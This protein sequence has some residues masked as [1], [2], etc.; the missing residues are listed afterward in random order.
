MHAMLLLL[1]CFTGLLTAA[2]ALGS[3]RIATWKGDRAAAF[4][5]MFD[6][7]TPSQVKNVVPELQ[8]RGLTG[9]F[10]INP[11]SGHYAG[12]R[13]AWEHDIPAAG[14]EL[15]NH[16]MT[17]KGAADLAQATT[18]I[19]GCNRVIHASTASLPWPRLI[20]WAQPG[21]VPWKLSAEEFKAL[22]AEHH[23]VP[24]PEFSGRSASI[25][26]KTTED[27]IR[28]VDKA[29]AA[30]VMECVIF[31][32]VGGDW[33]ATPMPV[34][35]GLL[36]TLVERRDKLW[37]TGHIPAHQYASA[38]DAAT[39]TVGE[40]SAKRIV[41]TLSCTADPALYDQPLT[42]VTAVPESWTQCVVTQ[43]G[44]TTAVTV[45]GGSVCYDASPGVVELRPALR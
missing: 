23:L 15:G 21:G 30:G 26:L 39:V 4:V 38:R 13:T 16:T 28:H 18:E 8:K 40:K 22:A 7:S 41:L 27:M 6:D 19:A 44:R 33:L 34:F 43:A 45:H 3:T 12:W 9:T 11:G 10:Y 29:Q 24:R 31:H 32:G 20:S 42:L 17:H 36:D 25:A 5:L 37:V 14:M 2:D 1:C 35:I